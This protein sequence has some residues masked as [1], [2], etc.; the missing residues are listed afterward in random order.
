MTCGGICLTNGNHAEFQNSL[1]CFMYSY[2]SVAFLRIH[3]PL[4]LIVVT[5][6]DNFFSVLVSCFLFSVL[7]YNQGLSA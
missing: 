3:L 7:V 5:N 2:F 1:I 6:F 4:D